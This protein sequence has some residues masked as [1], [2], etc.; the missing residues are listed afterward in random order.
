MDTFGLEIGRG[1]T[2]IRDFQDKTDKLGL[3]GK[4][5]F[6]SLSV[7]QSGGDTVI[8]SGND[9]LAVLKGESARGITKADFTKLK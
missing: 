8:S 5:K 4:L 1:S 3:M 2:L 7:E 9:V 6:G